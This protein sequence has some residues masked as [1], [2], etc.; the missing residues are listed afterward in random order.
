MPLNCPAVAS[1]SL[2][3]PLRPCL[4]GAHHARD[5]H[6]LGELHH[7]Q[8]DGHCMIEL[9]AGKRDLPRVAGKPDMNQ[10]ADQG[11]QGNC[12]GAA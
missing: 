12:A 4:P 5:R 1:A 8:G 11:S 10:A 6:E 2:S 7:D 3:G 9:K